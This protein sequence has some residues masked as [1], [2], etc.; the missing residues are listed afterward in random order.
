MSETQTKARP[1]PQF[2]STLAQGIDIL[3]C[4]KAH[5]SALGNKEF[6]ERTG[7][8]RSTVARLT[9][10]LLELGYLRRAPDSRR[11]RPGMS[12]LAVSYP[13]LASLRIRQLAWPLM[14]QLAEHINGAVSL[15]I[16]DRRQMVYVETVRMNEELHTYPDIGASLPMLSTAAGKAW[17]CRASS[18]DR[19]VVLNQIRVSEPAYYAQHIES[20]DE[21]AGD[22]EKKGYCGNNAQWRPDA[23]GFAVPMHKPINSNLF[24]FN[25]GVPASGGP[26]TERESDIAHKLV[27]LV[28]GVEEILG[29]RN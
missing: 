17:L 11:Y 14:A 26:F 7:L 21:A 6:S 24:V 19:N 3:A 18:H 1:D 29:L 2:A 9:H 12:L 22:L 23:Y 16:R 4:F 10:T 27:K 8:S 28:R 20:L 15:V 13:L 25:C 5:E